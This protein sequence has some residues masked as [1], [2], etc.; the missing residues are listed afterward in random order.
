MRVENAKKTE[1]QAQKARE[2][3]YPE[4]MM[5]AMPPVILLEKL[6]ARY[7]EWKKQRSLRKSQKPNED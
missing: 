5:P 4:F 7:S 1:H 2:P 6:A 3:Q